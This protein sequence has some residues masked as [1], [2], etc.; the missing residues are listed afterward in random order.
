MNGGFSD[1]RGVWL[2]LTS[3]KRLISEA[4][5]VVIPGYIYVNRVAG[6]LKWNT[7]RYSGG[8]NVRIGLRCGGGGG[9][10]NRCLYFCGLS[11]Y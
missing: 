9:V 7:G 8:K 1:V 6:G 3:P 2:S 10:V 11:A 4:Y 5:Y